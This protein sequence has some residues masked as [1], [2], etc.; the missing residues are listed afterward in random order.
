MG[1]G[2][3]LLARL[4]LKVKVY[5]AN[6]V[7]VYNL[8][9]S[10]VLNEIILFGF[11]YFQVFP[12]PLKITFSK[13]W[14]NFFFGFVSLM[15]YLKCIFTKCHY[16]HQHWQWKRGKNQFFKYFG[17]ILLKL[18]GKI[19]EIH[20]ISWLSI[21]WILKKSNSMQTLDEDI[22]EI[23]LSHWSLLK[24]KNIHSITQTLTVLNKFCVLS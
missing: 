3:T 24:K 16:F 21:T 6:L 14:I 9:K 15:A 4:Y 7:S 2:K 5:V 8:E 22:P 23:K 20:T 13:H 18:E 1:L 19:L 11:L 12:W 10:T 17:R